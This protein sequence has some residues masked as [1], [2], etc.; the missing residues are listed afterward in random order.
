MTTTHKHLNGSK[1]TFAWSV[2]REQ[3][4]WVFESNQGEVHEFIADELGW[5]DA[6]LFTPSVTDWYSTTL[7]NSN[8]VSDT[9][10][11]DHIYN[12]EHGWFCHFG[13][14][15]GWMPKPQP[16]KVKK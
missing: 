13:K 6:D 12:L 5:I 14:I 8:S 11:S 16:M 15:I 9:L 2:T 10:V 4:Y 7:F 1:W 3:H